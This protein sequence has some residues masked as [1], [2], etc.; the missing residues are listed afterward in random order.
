MC[1]FFLYHTATGYSVAI[2]RHESSDPEEIVFEKGDRIAIIGYFMKCMPWFVGRHASTGQVGFVHSS[3][4]NP[5]GF[6]ST[7]TE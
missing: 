1:L 6:P 4:V 2:I 7:A 3:H 5:D